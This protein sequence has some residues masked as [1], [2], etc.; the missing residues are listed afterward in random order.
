MPVMSLVSLTV[1]S[2]WLMANRRPS[3]SAAMK[4]TASSRRWARVLPDICTHTRTKSGITSLA[5][6][7]SRIATLPASGTNSL[8]ST[9]PA[10][11]AR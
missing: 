1:S 8:A 4:R 5:G 3:I 7:M 6:M 11:S 2:R 9:T 10:I